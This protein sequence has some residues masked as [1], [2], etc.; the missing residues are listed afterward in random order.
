MCSH[1]ENLIN[2]PED[3]NGIFKVKSGHYRA[4]ITK[5]YKSIYIGTYD[6]FNEALFARNNAKKRLFT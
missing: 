1:S 3:R 6:T 5:N 4:S 2:Q